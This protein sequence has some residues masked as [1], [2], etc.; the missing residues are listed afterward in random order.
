MRAAVL[1]EESPLRGPRA[2]AAPDT[3]GA[4]PPFP[5]PGRKALSML[6]VSRGDGDRE[7]EWE[8]ELVCAGLEV[9][10]EAAE[11]WSAS[12][13]ERYSAAGG[14]APEPG[15]RSGGEPG[16]DMEELEVLER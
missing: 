12:G 2:P 5:S 11:V 15:D 13:A 7:W 4:A 3:S 10:V 14:G 8:L 9:P 1:S 16:S 6:L